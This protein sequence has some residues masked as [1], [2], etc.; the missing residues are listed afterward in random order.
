MAGSLIAVKDLAASARETAVGP[1]ICLM[2]SASVS[3]GRDS[4]LRLA[5]GG[6]DGICDM[7]KLD[8]EKARKG[9]LHSDSEF[10]KLESLS[11]C[12]EYLFCSKLVL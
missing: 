11:S 1:S 10:R 4:R 7:S 3:L 8:L 2:I 5:D 6:R 9:R 12:R